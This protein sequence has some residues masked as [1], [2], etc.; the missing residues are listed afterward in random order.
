MH[1]ITPR[2]LHEAYLDLNKNASPGIDEVIWDEY[3]EEGNYVEKIKNLHERVQSGLYRALPSKRIYIPKADG[4]QR[5]IGIA[6]IEDK[7]V[8][9]AMVWVL[10]A[11]YEE[12]FHNFSYG[13][14]PGRNQHK[15]LD[16]VWM[17]I[18][19]RKVGWILDADIKGFFDNIDHQWMLKFL[20]HR[21]SD[22]RV[23]TLIRKWLRAGVS[24]DGEWSKTKIGTPQGAVISPLLANIYLHYVLD[25]WLEWWRK[26]KG[27]GEVYIVRY[28][29]DFVV[30]CQKYDDASRCWFEL[31]QRMKKFGLTLHPEKTRLIE[32]GRYAAQSREA[33]GKEKPETFNFLG[34]TH[35][36]AT[37][38]KSGNFTVRRQ[39]IAKRMREK[40]KEIGQ[41]LRSKISEGLDAMG[42]WLRSVVN[43]YYNYHAIPDNYSSMSQ[44]R[45]RVTEHWRR[46]L[47]RRSQKAKNNL[48]WA[49]MRQ[50]ADKWLPRFTARHPYPF[51]RLI[52]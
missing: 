44:F 48:T 14:R 6:A 31:S 20:E 9:K 5:P 22:Q 4:R 24:E 38:P 50:I 46:V 37:F 25:D 36:C 49:K 26:E 29:D 30:M 2:L 15:A 19:N 27:Q 12:D 11:I 21:I 23:L 10:E 34:F 18:T 16:A 41:L 45:D 28:A 43:G 13:F 52:V 1:H 35:M 17:A 51:R 8:Q 40:V 7:I 39:T 3:G 42:K 32:F 33:K 47:R